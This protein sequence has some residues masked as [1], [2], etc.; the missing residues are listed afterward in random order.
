[1]GNKANEVKASPRCSE[2]WLVSLFKFMGSGVSRVAPQSHHRVKRKEKAPPTEQSNCVRQPSPGQSNPSHIL[3]QQHP[4]KKH[5]VCRSLDTDKFNTPTPA[6]RR[7][8]SFAPPLLRLRSY[9]APLPALFAPT[10]NSIP[11]R[12]QHVRAILSPSD[13]QC[14]SAE[15]G[16]SQLDKGKLVG[17]GPDPPPY[18]FYRCR[19]RVNWRIGGLICKFS[20]CLI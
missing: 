20:E 10:E 2:V 3:I 8:P 6:H 15:D 9:E 13:H 19:I 17:W 5:P 11:G 14:R 16:R 4:E 7:N 1:M 12:T 18:I